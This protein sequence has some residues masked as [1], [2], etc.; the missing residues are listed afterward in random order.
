MTLPS[1]LSDFLRF[2]FDVFGEQYPVPAYDSFL[3][4]YGEYNYVLDHLTPG[5][6]QTIVDIGS[7][8]NLLL[9]YLTARGANVIG[10]DLNKQLEKK[11]RS[12]QQQ[13]ENIIKKNLA[14]SFKVEDATKLASFANDSV[15]VVTAISAIEHMFSSEGRGDQMAIDAIARV[16]KPGGVTIV[17]L[18]TSNGGPFHESSTGDARYHLPYRLYTPQAL[19]ERILSNPNLEVVDWSYLAQTTPDVRFDNLHFF[20]FWMALKP[21]ERWKWAWVQPHLAVLFNPRVSRTE[22]E[23]RLHTVNTALICMRKRMTA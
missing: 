1:T 7:D 6:G 13:V 8:A 20:N 15:D 17:T 12:R 4:R 11:I 18:P 9:F 22:G 10:V 14:L 3:I 21:E 23:S 16:L 19:E 5:A 2:E